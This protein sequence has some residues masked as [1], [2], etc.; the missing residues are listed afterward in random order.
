MM[1]TYFWQNA[2]MVISNAKQNHAYRASHSNRV[3]VF[4]IRI[5]EIDIARVVFS[6]MQT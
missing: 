2:N 5:C 1:L 6:S 4:D 3:L